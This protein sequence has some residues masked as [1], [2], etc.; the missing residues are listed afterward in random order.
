VPT[1]GSTRENGETSTTENLRPPQIMPL[2]QVWRM[3][4]Y[5]RPPRLVLLTGGCNRELVLASDGWRWPRRYTWYPW[6]AH[7][8]ACR[9]PHSLLHALYQSPRKEQNFCLS[10][11]NRSCESQP[12]ATQNYILPFL[13][14][15]YEKDLRRIIL[16]LGL[17]SERPRISQRLACN[18]L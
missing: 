3:V 16:T 2:E 5:Q 10:I 6:I 12:K 8:S 1:I 14:P 4:F 17:G 18:V 13:K 9:F 11:K 15:T 7:T